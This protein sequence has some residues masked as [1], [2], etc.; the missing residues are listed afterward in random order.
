[1]PGARIV[2][3][4]GERAVYGQVHR[5]AAP[6]EAQRHAPRSEVRNPAFEEERDDGRCEDAP[7]IALQEEAPGHLRDVR[8]V[9]PA[10]A[11]N[12]SS[13]SGPSE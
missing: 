2:R 13:R 10:E 6:V 1:V 5:K 12:R 3:Q 9:L 7:E 11:P 8:S 4:G